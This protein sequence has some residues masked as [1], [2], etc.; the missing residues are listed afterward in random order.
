MGNVDEAFV[1]LYNETYDGVLKYVL[2]KCG[3]PHDAPDIVQKTYLN[4]YERLKKTGGLKSPKATCSL[5]RRTRLKNTTVSNRRAK[6]TF[7]SFR[8][9]KKTPI[10]KSWKP[11]FHRTDPSTAASTFRKYGGLSGNGTI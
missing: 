10:L 9:A 5:S 7:R 8:A 4:Y 1:R 11:S 3:N 6:T 2:L